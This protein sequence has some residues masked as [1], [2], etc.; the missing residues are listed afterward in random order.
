MIIDLCD[1]ANDIDKKLLKTTSDPNIIFTQD[2]LR[3]MRCVRFASRFGFEIEENTL[4]CVKKF[5]SALNNISRER[6]QDELMKILASDGFLYGI[7]L[8]VS[9]DI[10]KNI[11]LPEINNA[12][13]MTQNAYHYADV[14]GHT[15]EVVKNAKP[16]ALHRLSALLHD[17][18]KT[19][20]K[21]IGDDGVVHFYN[22]EIES[23]IISR[24]FMTDLKFS[25]VDIDFVCTSVVNHMRISSTITDKKIRQ[26]RSELG[27]EHFAFLLDLCEADR[28]SCVDKN[29]SYIE[30]ARTLSEKE[31]VVTKSNLPLSGSDLMSM[32]NLKPGKIIG[33]L[34]K[35]ETDI[36]CEVPNIS[37]DNLIVE[38]TKYIYET[39]KN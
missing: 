31:V 18:G 36:L 11:G 24:R 30:R 13:G 39:N 1:G 34:I 15:L 9:L 19:V 10:F 29:A 25:N 6:I 38:L 28:L 35:I 37:K 20:T 5:A 32:F 16:T 8:C 12:V 27:N 22:H 7:C 33:E 14:Y 3:I 17:I 4:D 26:I 23:D 2:P 21:S